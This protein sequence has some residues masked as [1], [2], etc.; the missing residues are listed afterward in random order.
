MA[1][2]LLPKNLIRF[3]G[4]SENLRPLRDWF[5]DR[6]TV[7]KKNRIIKWNN[8]QFYF[9]AS[10]QV[11]LKASKHGIENSLTRTIIKIIKKDSNIID[12]G[13]NYGFITLALASYIKN[14][15]GI[16]YSFECDKNIFRNL[17]ASIKKNNLKNIKPYNTILGENNNSKIQ[18][19]DSILM[20]ESSI[21]DLIKIDT[22]GSDLECL[23]GCSNIIKSSHPIIVIEINNNMRLVVDYLKQLQYKFFYNQFLKNF[24]VNELE[25]YEIPNL[26]ATY[27]ELR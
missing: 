12:I 25:N 10:P 6:Y 17:K 24:R 23:K 26:I 16:I 1:S 13:A 27:Q 7:L 19:A 3:L 9:F 21:I 14:D 4:S 2:I 8:L 20:N 11:L 5:F 18:T 15:G 22:D